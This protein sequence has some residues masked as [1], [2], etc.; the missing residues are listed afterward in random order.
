M[1]PS[2]VVS[3]YLH[4]RD[5]LGL[6]MKYGSEKRVAYFEVQLVEYPNNLTDHS[7]GTA[8][9]QNVT[10]TDWDEVQDSSSRYILEPEQERVIYHFFYGI[11]PGQAWV[12]RRY[13]TNIDTNSL[14]GSR[15]IGDNV[16]YISGLDSPYRTPSPLTE[17]FTLKGVHPA[18]LGYN[19]YPEPASLNVRMNFFTARYDVRFIGVDPSNDGE[20]D[21][22]R[23]I[24][25][26]V[27]Q[28]AATLRTLGGRTPVDIPTWLESAMRIH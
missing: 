26:D 8:N 17:T 9:A 12:Y 3:K 1:L 28:R 7:L 25:P 10:G 5:I 16:G 14:I 18:Y 11:S 6:I 15:R 2:D 24:A 23:R 20:L 4:E 27:Y 22:Q 21:S 13:P 19:P